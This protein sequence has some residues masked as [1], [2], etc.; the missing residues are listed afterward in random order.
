[1][2]G[3]AIVPKRIQMSRERPWRYKHPDAVIV[4]RPSKWGNPF[5][6][7]QIGCAYPSLTAEQVHQMAV[8]QFRDIAGK[9]REITLNQRVV[10]GGGRRELVTYTYPPRAEI[11]AELRGR[12]VACWCG[13]DESCHG[14]VLLEIANGS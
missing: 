2:R 5:S 1:M 3:G 9:D 13:L 12:D 11:V 8:A 6:E 7:L 10:G 14:D 4:A